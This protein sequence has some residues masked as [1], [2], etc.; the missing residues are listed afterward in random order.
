M[1]FDEI[2]A[3]ISTPEDKDVAKQLFTKYPELNRAAMR[4]DEFSRKM[5]G[6]RE[7][8]EAV[9]AWEGWASQNWDFDNKAT[10]AE[11]ELKKQLS[12]VKENEMT[13]DQL[14][15]V[16]TEKGFV[17]QQDLS[18]K[19][20][21]FTTEMQGT[22]YVAA[23]LAEKGSEHALNFKEP[24][25]ATEFLRQLPKYGTTDLDL[26][27]GMHTADS[28]K[29]IEDAVRQAELEQVRKDA[30]DAGYK[31]AIEGAVANSRNGGLTPTDDGGSDPGFFQRRLQGQ[32]EDEAPAL[33]KGLARY[34]AQKFREES[35]MSG[36]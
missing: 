34:A 17:S 30:E 5:D 12:A 24:F 7:V 26:A 20:Q 36:Q 13:F 28:R 9:E 21:A 18:A 10:K 1:T 22:A 15:Q 2:I 25:K 8:Q 19:E 4:Q 23:W 31:K 29:K 27:Y 16:L 32:S 14:N 11:V 33:G 3:N 6:F 35:L